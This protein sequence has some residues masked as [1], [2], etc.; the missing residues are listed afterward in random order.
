RSS[1]RG[2]RRK[3]RSHPPTRAPRAWRGAL[4]SPRTPTVRDTAT[5]A[6]RVDRAAAP[7]TTTARLPRATRRTGTRR[8]R[9]ARSEARSG[10]AERRWLAA[11]SSAAVYRTPSSETEGANGDLEGCASACAHP[12]PGSDPARRLRALRGDGVRRRR[13]AGGCDHLRSE[14]HTS[15]L[16][17]LR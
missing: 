10:A 16:Q 8:G 13:T 1:T 6:R 4:A 12:D 2:A 5:P 15:E 7:A 3:L 11:T 14:E 9:G 17:S